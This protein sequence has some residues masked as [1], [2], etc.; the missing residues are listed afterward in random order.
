MDGGESPPGGR[1]ESRAHVRLRSAALPAEEQA[2]SQERGPEDPM[3]QLGSSAVKSLT[4]VTTQ[5]GTS[6]HQ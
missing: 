3:Y 2:C 5:A 4:G 6:G 1:R